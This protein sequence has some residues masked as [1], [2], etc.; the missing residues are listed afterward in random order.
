MAVGP[1]GQFRLV[2]EAVL[3]IS[4][5]QQLP[6][7]TGVMRIQKRPDG[8]GGDIAHKGALVAD[9]DGH[10]IGLVQRGGMPAGVRGNCH[11]L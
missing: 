8:R 2:I 10:L 9:G 7:I 3:V 6:E 5:D 11:C 4:T 1:V